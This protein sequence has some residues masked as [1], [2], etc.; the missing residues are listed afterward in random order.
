[1]RIAASLL[2]LVVLVGCSSIDAPIILGIDAKSAPVCKGGPVPAMA[3][4]SNQGGDPVAATAAQIPE[5]VRQTTPMQKYL[6]QLKTA[7]APAV[8]PVAVAIASVGP[9]SPAVQDVKVQETRMEL[10]NGEFR[11]F[12]KEFSQHVLSVA[13]MSPSTTDISVASAAPGDQTQ[14]RSLMRL[15]RF[16]LI[17]YSQGKYI[18]R[19]G[20]K[21]DAP[22]LS[23]GISNKVLTTTLAIF[24]DAIADFSF[25]EPV[26]TDGKVFY[27]SGKADAPTVL[28]T[29][30]RTDE[31]KDY[32]D[33]T[34]VRKVEL[35]KD[36][37]QCGL[38]DKEAKAVAVLGTLAE[39][40]SAMVSGIAA[41]AVSG[42]D[43]SFIVGGRFAFG[44]N[45][46]LAE[47]IKTFFAVSA[48]RASERAAYQFFYDFAYTEGST[49]EFLIDVG[50]ALAEEKKTE[51]KK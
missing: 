25:N 20:T 45:K 30:P 28:R 49:P 11:D 22:D 41:E 4:A 15:Y 3:F 27:P 29:G 47:L 21:Y 1:M 9:V 2:A 48:R 17:A 13:P 19:R 8:S 16:Y 46:T 10:S 40:K 36:P 7:Q 24:L 44:D 39:K 35:V 12:I 38:T 14:S 50:T 51:T 5:P 43:I 31:N 23:S 18:D 33:F 32:A 37:M 6:A 26:L 42:W 34:T